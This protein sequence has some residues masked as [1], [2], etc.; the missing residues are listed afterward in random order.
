M[1]T[2]EL[3]KE[4]KN[5]DLPAAAEKVLNGLA[6]ETEN[7][8]KRLTSKVQI[9]TKT[10]TPKAFLQLLYDKFKDKAVKKAV[11]RTKKEGKQGK[12]SLLE[13]LTKNIQ[14]ETGI[15]YKRAKATAEKIIK[16]RRLFSG[17][18]QRGI[19]KDSKQPAKRFGKRISENG[20]VYYEYRSNR[21]DVPVSK[22]Y[23]LLEKGG[24]IEDADAKI[25]IVS[26]KD[27]NKGTTEGIWID[28]SKYSTGSDI[29]EAIDQFLDSV[30][31]KNA[32][33]EGWADEYAAHDFKGFPK[34]F[35]STDMVT[36]DFDRLL[37]FLE[38]AKANHLPLQV[39]QEYCNISGTNIID[40]EAHVD[41]VYSGQKQSIDDYV[42]HVL[43]NNGIPEE[44][45]PYI[46]LVGMGMELRKAFDAKEFEEF[47]D[48]T[49][50]EIAT[51]YLSE[52]YGEKIPKKTVKAYF[53]TQKYWDEVLSKETGVINHQ[54]HLYFFSKEAAPAY[55]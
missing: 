48:S 26:L 14:V 15:S 29:D 19:Q 54:G 24:L 10:D 9:G 50:I 44:S 52:A 51:S 38:A 23:P 16:E 21:A 3:V 1:N 20:N 33:N 25:F 17:R 35:F 11:Q 53:K 12:T 6:K 32:R 27:Y 39:I 31:K 34:E 37:D 43:E 2:K 47:E 45:E 7:F 8:T 28:L 36:K 18:T 42:M 41:D 4:L 49:D 30:D 40:F 13:L 5:K 55:V 46:D 22:R